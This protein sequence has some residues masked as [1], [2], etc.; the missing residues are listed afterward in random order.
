MNSLFIMY[1]TAA[2]MALIAAAC[3]ALCLAWS[4]PSWRRR[5]AQPRNAVEANTTEPAGLTGWPARIG[6]GIISIGIAA[7]AAVGWYGFYCT[8]SALSIVAR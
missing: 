3:T 7:C 4:I 8:L 5:L 2:L 6:R 1:V